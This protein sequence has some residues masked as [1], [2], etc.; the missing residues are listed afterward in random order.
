MSRLKLIFLALFTMVSQAFAVDCIRSDD[1][2]IIDSSIQEMFEGLA[3]RDCNCLENSFLEDKDQ[4]LT[5]MYSEVI[6]VM[7]D[8]M[9]ESLLPD[10]AFSLR[11]Y[12]SIPRQCSLDQLNQM[13]CQGHR[14][15]LERAF[16]ATL[17]SYLGVGQ[18]ES[19]FSDL[20]LQQYVFS[21]LKNDELTFA[22]IQLEGTGY[23]ISADPVV[24]LY[25]EYN[26]YFNEDMNYQQILEVIESN[27][28][29]SEVLENK[30]SEECSSIYNSL[31][32]VL[33]EN[34]QGVSGIPVDMISSILNI[35]LEESDPELVSALVCY[36]QR[37]SNHV[38]GNNPL[39]DDSDCH[40]FQ[41]E[42]DFFNLSDLGEHNLNLM[43]QI[44]ESM[45]RKDNWQ[46]QMTA[47][48]PLFNCKSLDEAADVFFGDADYC[49]ETISPA[50]TME[51]LLG[52]LNCDD[53]TEVGLEFCFDDLFL[54]LE[55]V[56]RYAPEVRSGH[57]ELAEGIDFENLTPQ[58]RNEV[59]ES[60]GFTTDD[61]DF[62]GELGVRQVFGQTIDFSPPMISQSQREFRDL[63]AGSA[64]Q[65][66][67][68][69]RREAQQ[70]FEEQVAQSN[71]APWRSQRAEALSVARDF[72][73]PLPADSYRNE[74]ERD[75]SSMRDFQASYLEHQNEIRQQNNFQSA[76]NSSMG[77]DRQQ[78]YEQSTSELQRELYRIN[79]EMRRAINEQEVARYQQKIRN[80]EESLQR[81]RNH[82]TPSAVEDSAAPAE[83]RSS[84]SE[85][86]N[87]YYYIVNNPNSSLESDDREAVDSNQDSQRRS[88]ER[89]IASNAREV[90][91]IQRDVQELAYLE[92]E[93]LLEINLGDEFVLAFLDHDEL[94]TIEMRP[95]LLAGELYYNA[96]V[97]PHISVE[98][99]KRLMSSPF[100][101]SYLHPDSLAEILNAGERLR[102]E[103][104][105]NILNQEIES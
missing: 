100:F 21:M 3:C 29:L 24:N 42:G 23:A 33:C 13:S 46:E 43:V 96:I 66:S 50:R 25:L 32:K 61:I 1:G 28:A 71:S 67:A 77:S 62:L 9:L 89:T 64:R 95:T 12:P 82:S 51:Q 93:N 88:P 38:I 8:Y 73:S 69:Q 49:R 27:E 102:H 72:P 35:D 26:S 39:N 90:P 54:G 45:A 92:V 47:Y 104:L 68:Q 31:D 52:E 4:Q 81:V 11:H 99:K 79:E 86:V 7:E 17:N 6:N 41:Q 37:C 65:R 105:L 57:M 83:S 18:S 63:G 34:P 70:R 19:C 56:L 91:M 20:E 103:D 2:L 55:D 75:E 44:N 87:Q 94:I 78:H 15:S 48:C 80:L 22:R 10:L 58:Q 97:P 40:Y 76:I 98:A 36:D 60:Y 84:D 53:P 5:L 74:R 30:M 16:Q 14:Q 85:Q 101:K 59:L